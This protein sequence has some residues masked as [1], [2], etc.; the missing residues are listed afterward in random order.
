MNNINKIMSDMERFDSFFHGYSLRKSNL[1]TFFLGHKPTEKEKKLHRV[2]FL[3]H[4]KSGD[5]E[6]PMEETPN[7]LERIKNKVKV[8]LSSSKY[9]LRN[10]KVKVFL[11]GYRPSKEEAKI[12]RYK[13][14]VNFNTFNSTEYI[15][16]NKPNIFVRSKNLIILAINQIKDILKKSN[17]TIEKKVVVDKIDF[18]NSFTE[19]NNDQEKNK[20]PTLE[21]V[22]NNHINKKNNEIH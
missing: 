18:L 4:Y 2:K 20:I 11:F 19:M 1:K 3:V 13:Y 14:L 5:Q 7:V 10:N 22:L 21:N 8:F 16:L 17:P 6:I 15:Q 9:F 12:H